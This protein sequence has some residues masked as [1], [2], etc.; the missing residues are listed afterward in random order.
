MQTKPTIKIRSLTHKKLDFGAKP[1][2]GS[3]GSKAFSGEPFTWRK[4]ENFEV[5]KRPGNEFQAI[6]R[7][8]HAFQPNLLKPRIRRGHSCDPRCNVTAPTVRNE[9]EVSEVW[10]PFELN[11]TNLWEPLDQH[12]RTHSVTVSNE[13]F[14]PAPPFDLV[15]W[16]ADRWDRVSV[17]VADYE[18]EHVLQYFLRK[19]VSQHHLLLLHIIINTHTTS[20]FVSK[21]KAKAKTQSQSYKAKLNC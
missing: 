21:W 20:R 15:P 8:D 12:P 2:I 5:L 9:V 14:L 16:L 4:H 7:N 3:N 1:A 19:R 11:G 6:I 13:D 10:L 17:F 18:G